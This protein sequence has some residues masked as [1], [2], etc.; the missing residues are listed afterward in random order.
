M[1]SFYKGD[2]RKV[3]INYKTRLGIRSDFMKF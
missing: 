1:L 3:M 2:T